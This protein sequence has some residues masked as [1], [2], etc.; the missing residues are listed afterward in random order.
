[1]SFNGA[2]LFQINTAGQPVVDNTLIDTTVFNALTTDLATG[3]STCVTKDGQTTPTAN[4]PMG[5]FKITG[6]GLGTATTDA[7]SVSN[8][9][10]L[11]TCEF[12]LTVFT[13]TPV[14]TIDIL[15]VTTIY[16][17][18]YKGN[19]IALYDGSNWVM[20][21]SAEMSIAVPNVANTIHDVFCYDNAG[22]P[23]LELT[24]W[25]N[26]T[27]RATALTRLNG[28]RVKSGTPTRRYLGSFRTT[29][30]AGQTEDSFAKRYVWN[31]H[32]RVLR[33]MRVIDSTDTW[34]YT[35]ATW[36]QA[37]ANTANQIDF[38]IGI[39]ED[40]VSAQVVGM[41]KNTGANVDMITGIGLDSTSAV[42]S[43]TLFYSG[44]SQVANQYVG[45]GA[46]LKIYPSVGRHFLAWLEISNASG[47]TTWSGDAG[48]TTVQSGIHGEIWG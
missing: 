18:E 5:G 10:S 3:L 7:M 45:N 9:N 27:T 46:S 40:C 23:T 42:A 37:N 30:V 16:A 2:G 38:V 6:L 41:A 26:D 22:V 1:M 4:I 19:N 25:T 32:N 47:T 11:H 15:A 13:A 29:A 43:G 14:T 20:R 28:V 36:R 48:T 44:L 17:S 31:Y 8:A 34:N 21:S 39:V 12:R 24:A 33:P 35:T